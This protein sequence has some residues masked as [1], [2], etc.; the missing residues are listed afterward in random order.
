MY[1]LVDLQFTLY[2]PAM[3]AKANEAPGNRLLDELYSSLASIDVLS[4]PIPDVKTSTIGF[5][6]AALSGWH[7]RAL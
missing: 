3:L 7:F 2:W 5:C 4:K 1:D 6:A